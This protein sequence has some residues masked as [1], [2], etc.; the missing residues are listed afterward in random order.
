MYTQN[1]LIAITLH[2]TEL[3]FLI[4]KY[5]NQDVDILKQEEWWNPKDRLEE[6][7][8]IIT[9]DPLDDYEEMCISY[10]GCGCGSAERYLKK[11]VYDGY[12]NEG[13]YFL[14]IGEQNDL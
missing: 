5:Y 3:N 6:K 13:Y 2:V 7:I 9:K 8:G 12:L 4:K 14:N 10:G 11:L 1:E